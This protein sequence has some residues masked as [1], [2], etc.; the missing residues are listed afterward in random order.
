MRLNLWLRLSLIT[1]V[2]LG[3]KEPAGVERSKLVGS[4]RQA[5]QNLSPSG[6][7]EFRL[8]FTESG[9]FISDGSMYGV[10]SGQPSKELSAY[11]RIE[12]TY[13]ADGDRLVLNPRRLTT[14]DRFF[15]PS[16]PEKV[17][18]PYPYSE[19][20]DNARYHLEGSTLTLNYTT[21]PADAPIA[22]TMQLK[23]D[24]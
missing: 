3:C 20:F 16:S 19:Y 1:A 24:E 17:Y 12:G 9:T 14:W 13:V 18:D 21:Y 10:Y 15:G 5:T 6:T 2:A 7:Y 11:T 4:W 23:R 8:T 22:T